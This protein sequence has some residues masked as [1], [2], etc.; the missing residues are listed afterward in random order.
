MCQT[1][2]YIRTW[3]RYLLNKSLLFKYYISNT[4]FQMIGGPIRWWDRCGVYTDCGGRRTHFLL[5]IFLKTD[6]HA[7]TD[8]GIEVYSSHLK[9]FFL[10]DNTI[11]LAN[12]T[13]K[14]KDIWILFC[15]LLI[16]ISSTVPAC[17][18]QFL[19]ERSEYNLSPRW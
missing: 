5:K 2:Q 8:L 1:I 11:Y 15:V 10:T 9:C 17:L 3:S 14:S 6:K 16:M 7:W 4:I 12:P 19:F 18:L 13:I